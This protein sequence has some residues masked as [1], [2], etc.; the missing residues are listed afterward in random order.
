MEAGAFLDLTGASFFTG[1]PDSLLR[2]FCDCL[3]D[4]FGI[5]STQ[6]VV[7]ANEGNAVGIAAGYHLAT[8]AVPL[9]YLQNSGEGNIINP[10]ASLLHEKVYAIPCIFVIGWRGEPGVHDEPQHV[11]QGEVTCQ[12]LET[13]GVAC[14][15]I[16]KET[17]EAEVKEAMQSFRQPL[18]AGKQVA[19]VVRKDALWYENKRTFQND[20]TLG[21]EE[22]IREIVAVSGEDPVVCT[23]GKASRELFEIRK[24]L[25]Q[26]HARDFLTVGSMGHASSI[27]LGIAL[28]KPEKTV[29]C[30]DGDG[31][32]L[33]HLGALPVIGELRVKNLRHIMV[34]N[35]AHES[36]GGMPTAAGNRAFDRVAKE[37]GYVWAET[38]SDPEALRNALS[39]MREADGPAFLEIRCSLGARKDLG[40]PDTTPQEN[41]AAFMEAL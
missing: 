28:Q 10:L 12:L 39:R 35:G 20:A 9:V 22:A 6:H 30:I 16:G 2:P 27:A 13:M 29:W 19:F 37:C 33:M 4:R 11:F 1:V 8:G 17:T 38:V 18:S 41:K 14:K 26:S 24:A 5:N 21:R 23:T 15:V 32:V 36:V 3:C 40:R 25:G 7:A 34:N 31:A